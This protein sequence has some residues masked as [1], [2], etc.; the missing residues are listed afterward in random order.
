[1]PHPAAARFTF[2]RVRTRLL[3]GLG[4]AIIALGVVIAPIPG[5]GGVPV[6]FVGGLLVLRNSPDSRRLFVRMKRRH[7]RALAPFERIR[8]FFRRRRQR[9]AVTGQA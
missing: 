5:P 6:A 7:P 2:A 1:M 3:I 8:V 9:A 4:W